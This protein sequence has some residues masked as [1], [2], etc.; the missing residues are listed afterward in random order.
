MINLL[1]ISEIKRTTSE[2]HMRLVITSLMMLVLLTMVAII[3]LAPSYLLASHKR[4]IVQQELAKLGDNSASLQEQKDLEAVV[5]QTESAIQ[6]LSLDKQGLL[7]SQDV[8]RKI[9]W[10]GTDSIKITGIYYDVKNDGQSVS[11]KGFAANRKS[12]TDFADMLKR[13]PLFSG[14]SLPISDLVK[15]KDINFTIM[16]NVVDGTGA[17][18]SK[19]S[20]SN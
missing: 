15:D 20:P 14:A 9:S 13:D 17:A 16:I 1:P 3:S 19:K 2:Y 5:K 6:L 12:L 18:N 8:M 4:E 7:V 10:Y 11:L